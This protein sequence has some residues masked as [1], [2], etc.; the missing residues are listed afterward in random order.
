[1]NL[2]DYIYIGVALSVFL[3]IFMRALEPKNDAADITV[4]LIISFIGGLFWI[5]VI[6]GY[7]VYKACYKLKYGCKTSKYQ[8]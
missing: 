7:L 3:Y 5:L 2:F 6:P 8:D 1:M 4:Y